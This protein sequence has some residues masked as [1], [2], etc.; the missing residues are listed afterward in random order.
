MVFTLIKVVPPDF[1]S[2]KF[3]STL[4][5]YS[6]NHRLHDL[7]P[8]ENTFDQ[9][10]EKPRQYQPESAEGQ[11]STRRWRTPALLE[12]AASVWPRKSTAMGYDQWLKKSRAASFKPRRPIAD[13]LHAGKGPPPH[14]GFPQFYDKVPTKFGIT[15]RPI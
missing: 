3:L 2:G 15:P 10:W 13:P 11:R 5:Q 1:P 7:Q 14:V 9:A 12:A 4:S 6:P 8:T